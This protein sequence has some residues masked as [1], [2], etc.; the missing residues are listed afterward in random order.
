MAGAESVLPSRKLSQLLLR[1][2]IAVLP[3][4][5]A[6]YTKVTTIVP[7]VYIFLIIEMKLHVRMLPRLKKVDNTLLQEYINLSRQKL[8]IQDDTP[9]DDADD[10]YPTSGGRIAGY[11]KETA[12]AEVKRFVERYAA[13]GKMDNFHSLALLKG[14]WFSSVFVPMLLTP[15][16]FSQI[17]EDKKKFI[18][19]LLA[20]SE[21]KGSIRKT[22]SPEIVEKWKAECLRLEKEATH[23]STPSISTPIDSSPSQEHKLLA[24]IDQ[25]RALVAQKRSK[26][27]EYPNS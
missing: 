12:E 19:A 8:G 10:T 13:T 27:S 3:F 6:Y 25:L 9:M 5:P 20:Q 17:G 4:E 1:V 23:Q 21:T 26:E 7:L 22:I 16:P 15:V 2:L 11:S 14:P 24:L 18:A